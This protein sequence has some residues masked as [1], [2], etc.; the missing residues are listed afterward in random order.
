MTTMENDYKLPTLGTDIF[1]NTPLEDIYV[2]DFALDDFIAALPEYAGGII[3]PYTT[4]ATEHIQGTTLSAYPNPTYDIVNITGLSA[5]KPVFVYSMTGTLLNTY[6]APSEILT[7]DIKNLEKG[8]Y[9]IV[10][11]GKAVKVIRK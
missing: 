7:I 1:L 5:G 9:I 8:M 6:I 11:E 10:Y 4:T 3:K 2:P